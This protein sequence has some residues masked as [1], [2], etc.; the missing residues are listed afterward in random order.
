MSY[1]HP[2]TWVSRLLVCCG[3]FRNP[4]CWACAAATGLLAWHPLHVKSVIWV[5]EHKD[6]LSTFF[7][8]L[9]LHFYFSYVKK[10]SWKRYV[11]VLFCMRFDEQA[12]DSDFAG[13]DVGFE[14]LVVA[15]LDWGW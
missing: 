4:G 14:F 9:A 6:V 13:F 11:V 12:D 15:S 10:R 1:W 3:V 5:S 2:L 8:L 7:V